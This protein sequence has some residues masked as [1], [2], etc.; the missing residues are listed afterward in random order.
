MSYRS[1]ALRPYRSQSI[2]FALDV[3]IY[4]AAHLQ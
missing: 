2:L 3:P 4:N 1:M